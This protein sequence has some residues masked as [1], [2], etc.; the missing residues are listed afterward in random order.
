MAELAPFETYKKIPR[1][2]GDVHVTEKLDG[3]NACFEYSNV[4][5]YGTNT[6][7]VVGA[8]SRNRRLFT[9]ELGHDGLP[10]AAPR[11]DDKGD[12]AGFGAWVLANLD[13]LRRLGYGRHF[14]EWYGKGIQRGY[15]LEDKRFALFRAP[16]A[17]VPEG[18]PASV[19]P[20]LDV[21]G[22]FDT[23]R[24]AMLLAE[25]RLTGSRAAPGYMNPE[26]IVIFHA[27]S[28]QLFKYT[29]EA[30]PKGTTD[31]SGHPLKEG[32]V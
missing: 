31:E 7:Y 2:H 30:G 12:N 32:F 29:F 5:H 14:G 4:A 22:E 20:E 8:C 18:C 19:V 1:L 13:G 6:A 28:G 17:G 11:W 23:E 26:G 10:L 21:W 3:T 16:K 27:R 25:L 15:G 9:L 24:L